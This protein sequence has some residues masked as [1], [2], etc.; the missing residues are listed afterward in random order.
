MRRTI[1]AAAAALCL[2]LSAPA[3][4]AQIELGI[5]GGASSPVGQLA[6]VVGPGWHGGVVLD[7]G[8]PLLPLRLRADLMF[9]RLPGVEGG[10]SFDQF[11]GTVNGRLGLLPIP[12][13]SAY[14]T[15]GAGMY[16]SSFAQAPGADTG[17]SIDPGVNIGVGASVNLV[18]L[19]PFVEAR[20]HRVLTDPGR[21][22]VPVT[23]G[24]YF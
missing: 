23:F 5:G 16:S 13:L 19:R 20:Y 7:A 24:V 15:A 6:D 22:F 2:A 9:Q 4:H 1:F 10:D 3:A 14:V 21:G 11:F 8:V 18:V 12:L 17:R